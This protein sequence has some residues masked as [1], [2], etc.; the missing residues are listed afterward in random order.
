MILKAQK[1]KEKTGRLDFTKIENVHNKG[2][3][4]ESERTTYTWEKIFANH[5]FD[6]GIVMQNI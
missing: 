2:H 6:K 1:K 4:Q 5:I 3:Y